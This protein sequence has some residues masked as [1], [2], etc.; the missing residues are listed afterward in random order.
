MGKS[1]FEINPSF[2]LPS[3][4]KSVKLLLDKWSDILDQPFD[5]VEKKSYFYM[6]TY[7]IRFVPFRLQK[8]L[9]HGIFALLM[10]V[11]WL[12]KAVGEKDED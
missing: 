8:N 12:N 9:D 1:D 4:N 2:S 3:S 11:I 5:L 6:S 7:F 10:A